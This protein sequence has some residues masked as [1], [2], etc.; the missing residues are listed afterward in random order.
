[1]WEDRS[2][3]HSHT[4]THHTAASM[5]P[6]GHTVNKYSLRAKSRIWL[7]TEHVSKLQVQNGCN[8][9]QTTSGKERQKTDIFIHIVH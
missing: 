8:V 3:A 7:K 9:F 5:S 6:V 2:G 1:M 4:H